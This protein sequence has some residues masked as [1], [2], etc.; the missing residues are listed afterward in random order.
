MT[1]RQVLLAALL[2]IA[3]TCSMSAGL[4]VWWDLAER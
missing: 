1:L 2:A 3:M 4:W